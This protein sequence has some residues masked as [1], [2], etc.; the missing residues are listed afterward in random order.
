MKILK[1]IRSTFLGSR[2]MPY[3]RREWTEGEPIQLRVT[4]EGE[5]AR[6]FQK[7]KERHG[8]ESNTDLVRMII[9]K[10]YEDMTK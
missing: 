6:R 10:Y 2:A 8:F 5:M 4:L 7:I 9:S 1:S 3:K